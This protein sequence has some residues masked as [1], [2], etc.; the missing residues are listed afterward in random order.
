[1]A[2]VE[3]SG[4][5]SE[6]LDRIAAI[7]IPDNGKDL[8]TIKLQVESLQAELESITD[9][10]V[11][12]RQDIAKIPATD[13][14]NIVTKPEMDVLQSLVARLSNYDDAQVKGMLE[15][16]I[17]NTESLPDDIEAVSRKA[18]LVLDNQLSLL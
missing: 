1:M 16:L 2:A 14:S 4:A 8:A 17:T 6:V 13:L 9:S 12:V 3:R 10:V 7:S 11:D 5:S 18:D 15:A